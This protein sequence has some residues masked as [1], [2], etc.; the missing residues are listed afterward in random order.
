MAAAAEIIRSATT[1]TR[2]GQFKPSSDDLTCFVIPSCE[3]SEQFIHRFQKRKSKK[4]MIVRFPDSF[5]DL[6]IESCVR[7]LVRLSNVSFGTRCLDQIAQACLRAESLET[8]RYL[9]RKHEYLFPPYTKL[10]L[11]VYPISLPS[12]NPPIVRGGR[13][14]RFKRS[15]SIWSEN[16][17]SRRASRR[18][19]FLGAVRI[20][21]LEFYVWQDSQR[22]FTFIGGTEQEVEKLFTA[23]ALHGHTLDIRESA[24][25]FS[26][27]TPSPELTLSPLSPILSG[28]SRIRTPLWAA[29]ALERGTDSPFN[30]HSPARTKSHDD[31]NDVC[32]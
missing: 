10:E 22:C 24:S 3:T 31:V 1:L 4:N 5:E 2:T 13:L 6:S 25:S 8:A 18:A 17:S 14:A 15:V 28:R 29:A 32:L 21:P 11:G 19:T 26:L 23:L 7:K 12:K 16:I 20:S 9:F 30:E 27:R